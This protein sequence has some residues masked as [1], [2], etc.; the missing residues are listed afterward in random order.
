MNKE[1]DIRIAGVQQAVWY[2]GTFCIVTQHSRK[3]YASVKFSIIK[4]LAN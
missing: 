2:N 4:E 3:I 1:Q